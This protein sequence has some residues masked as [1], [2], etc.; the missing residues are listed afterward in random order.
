MFHVAFTVSLHRLP[1]CLTPNVPLELV[2]TFLC[3]WWSY[4]ILCFPALKVWSLKVNASIL[5]CLWITSCSLKLFLQNALL[6]QLCCSH[7]GSKLQNQ[8]FTLQRE[9]PILESIHN[10]TLGTVLAGFG[11]S[12]VSCVYTEAKWQHSYLA[13]GKEDQCFV[14]TNNTEHGFILVLQI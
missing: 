11:T 1:A 12:P 4:I 6:L 5:L 10:P 2:N 7:I 13:G 9:S 8:T 3:V 14:S